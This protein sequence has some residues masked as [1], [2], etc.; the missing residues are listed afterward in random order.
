MLLKWILFIKNQTISRVNF[1]V[2]CRVSML[3]DELHRN[4]EELTV[5]SRELLSVKE[6]L[7]R[8]VAE[9]DQ[10]ISKLQTELTSLKNKPHSPGNEEFESRV[11]TL[12]DT[13]LSKQSQ[14]ERLSS[15]KQ[16]LN[17]QLERMALENSSANGS[18]RS[19]SSSTRVNMM[20]SVFDDDGIKPRGIPAFC[21]ES[22]FDNQ[23]IKLLKKGLVAID[24]FSLTVGVY[25][26]RFALARVFIVIYALLLHLWVTLVI[27]TYKP[28]MHSDD[29]QPQIKPI[30]KVE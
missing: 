11:R 13:L 12:T 30:M 21:R 6:K 25:F 2:V 22:A 7:S 4:K 3:E 29:F 16:S 17:F 26:R 14:I 10:S 20:T 27:L 9:K 23:F 5:T 19:G 1:F 28:E 15:E 8:I 18:I 24:S